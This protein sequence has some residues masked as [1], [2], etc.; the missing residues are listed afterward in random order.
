[1][2]L[3]CTSLLACFSNVSHIQARVLFKGVSKKVLVHLFGLHAFTIEFFNFISSRRADNMAA[4]A[5]SAASFEH[6]AAE[7]GLS[8]ADIDSF[9]THDIKNFNNLAFSVCSQLDR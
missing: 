7:I 2:G 4:Y 9:K 1:M 3:E 5:Q 6:R 8:T